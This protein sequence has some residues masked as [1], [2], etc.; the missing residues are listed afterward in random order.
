MLLIGLL[1]HRFHYL[2]FYF[3]LSL[4]MDC[5][6]PF[7]CFC[8]MF[9][10]FLWNFIGLYQISIDFMKNYQCSLAIGLLNY[11]TFKKS[12]SFTR[13]WSWKT[14]TWNI[15]TT[16]WP[17]WNFLKTS[18]WRNQKNFLIRNPE[19]VLQISETTEPSR[20]L[21]IDKSQFKKVESENFTTSPSTYLHNT[22]CQLQTLHRKLSIYYHHSKP[23]SLIHPKTLNKITFHP[24]PLKYDITL[25]NIFSSQ[26]SKKRSNQQHW[27]LS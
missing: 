8:K 3:I 20:S 18:G 1:M 19:F 16:S 17:C 27:K 14:S 26:T 6:F 5:V 10:H 7:F 24:K 15:S 13:F 23:N 21:L 25:Y 11:T 12:H 9:L 2:N 4:N 22:K